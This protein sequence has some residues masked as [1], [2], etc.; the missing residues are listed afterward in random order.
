M[1]ARARARGLYSL[2]PLL[3]TTLLVHYVLP[4]WCPVAAIRRRA[5]AAGLGFSVISSRCLRPVNVCQPELP[6]NG[7]GSFKRKPRRRITAR[8]GGHSVPP[9]R[10]TPGRGL[11]LPK[12]GDRNG[13]STDC[14][15]RMLL[16]ELSGGRRPVRAFACRTAGA[17]RRWRDILHSL[18]QGSRS[19]LQGP[20][21]SQGASADTGVPDPAGH[22]HVL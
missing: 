20:G 2:R 8:T 12:G 11:P 3:R 9:R 14:E 13:R 16:R 1:A 19:M 22:R 5:V 18:P 6:A 17:R 15:C 7:T 4:R 21:I 10:H